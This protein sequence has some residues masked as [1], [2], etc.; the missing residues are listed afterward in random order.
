MSRDWIVGLMSGTSLDGVDAALLRSDGQRIEAAG[1]TLTQP[2]EPEFRAALRAVLGGV[3]DVAGVER[4][5]TDRHAQAVET[6]LEQAGLTRS[7]IALVGFHGQTIL[8]A[9]DEGRTWQI[10]DGRR[11]AARLGLPVVNDFRSADMAAGGEG[12]PLAPA[13]HR[14]LAEGLEKPLA[15]LNLGGVSNVT[16]IGPGPEDL[17]AGD[18]GPANALLDDWMLARRGQRYDAEGRLAASG[19]A[20]PDLLRQAMA[21]P[22]FTRPLPKSLDRDAFRIEGLDDLDDATG[23]ATLT[24]FTAAAVAAVVPLLPARPKRWLVTGGGRHNPT[25]M[26][27]L[28]ELLGASVE[29]VEQVGWDGDA[30]EAQAFAFL[31]A[32]SLAGLP[33]TYPGTTGVAAPLSG[34]CLQRPSGSS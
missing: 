9:P 30:L 21:H 4:A 22:F 5:L 31:A 15:V 16:W 12:A 27:A 10:G 1:A 24:A 33:L 19:V 26:A 11:L 6:L 17:V 28:R 20:R 29:P 23:A 14:A 18:C 3:G 34:G 25:M 13:Y 8:H 32:R 7:E 2:Y